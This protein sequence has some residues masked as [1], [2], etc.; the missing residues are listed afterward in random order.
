MAVTKSNLEYKLSLETKEAQRNT[1]KFKG[2][3]KDLNDTIEIQNDS[4]LAIQDNLKEV[5][6][7]YNKVSASLS[8]VNTET[9][10]YVNASNE[11]L[12]TFQKINN[13]L[14]SMTGYIDKVIGGISNL[15]NI[16]EL[17]TSP[18]K[19]TKLSKILYILSKVADFKGYNKIGNAL[20]SAAKELSIYSDTLVEYGF[21]QQNLNDRINQYSAN[22]K[23]MENVINGVTIATI[24]L[25]LAFL[26][27]TAYQAGTFEVVKQTTQA[28]RLLATSIPSYINSIK[29]AFIKDF[30]S[31]NMFLSKF[32]DRVK[33]N[34]SFKVPKLSIK[35]LVIY[36]NNFGSLQEIF[37]TSRR[38]IEAINISLLKL[39]SN[40]S[41]TILNNNW[42]E[43]ISS[44]TIFREKF[45][46]IERLFRQLYSNKGLVI[47][48][49]GWKALINVFSYFRESIF[50]VEIPLKQLTS[51]E[52]VTAF[53]SVLNNSNKSLTVLSEN[54]NRIKQPS[55]FDNM[56]KFFV[57]LKNGLLG[58]ISVLQKSISSISFYSIEID[59]LIH[60]LQGAFIVFKALIPS[61][62]KFSVTLLKISAIFGVLALQ[63]DLFKF[64]LA[65]FLGFNNVISL[66]LLLFTS[67]KG[68]VNE[69]FISINGIFNLSK[70]IL[71]SFQ[72]DIAAIGAL[73]KFI[74]KLSK[75]VI[76]LSQN[77]V[78]LVAVSNLLKIVIISFLST[79]NVFSFLL[80]STVN[81]RMALEETVFLLK[82]FIIEIANAVNFI[83]RTLYLVLMQTFDLFNNIFSN[84]FNNASKFNTSLKQL[85][86][87][88]KG[89]VVYRENSLKLNDI[90]LVLRK[91]AV[92]LKQSLKQLTFDSKA[93]VLF[94]ENMLA[95]NDSLILS[96][97]RIFAINIPFRQL[98]EDKSLVIYQG[99]TKTLIETFDEF[100]NKIYA[101]SRAL[102][103]LAFDYIGSLNI[104]VMLKEEFKSF[105]DTIP[106]AVNIF[107]KLSSAI[108]T[109]FNN[110]YA[111]F[112]NISKNIIS[113]ISGVFTSF[114][115]VL[116]GSSFLQEIRKIGLSIFS[117]FSNIDFK[118]AFIKFIQ[119]VPIVF[120]QVISFF[121]AIGQVGMAAFKVLQDGA[122]LSSIIF[123]SHLKN[124]LI[125]AFEYSTLLGNGFLALGAI[126][127]NTDSTILKIVGTVSLLAGIIFGGFGNA[128]KFALS[129]LGNF[130][131]SIGNFLETT[132]SSFEEKFRK[133]EI[134]IKNFSF[135]MV[136]FS[137]EFGSAIGTAKEWNNAISD[138][139]DNTLI[140]AVDAR[141]MAT[142]IIQVG[143]SLGLTKDQ[144]LALN[145]L[146]PDYVKAGDD[147][148]DVTV[149]FLQALTGMGQGVIKYGLHVSEAAVEHSKYFKGL[150]LSFDMLTES[151]K[152]EARLATIMEQAA[153]VRGRAAEQLNT[154]AGAQ[155]F[156]NNQLLRAQEILGQQNFLI[157][158]MYLGLAKAASVLVSLPSGFLKLVGTFQDVLAVLS[159]ITGVIFAYI[160]PVGALISLY[161][162]LSAAIVKVGT[163]QTIL[164]FVFAKTAITL[165]VTSV[166][167]TSLNTVFLNL[168]I[169]LKGTIIVALTSIGEILLTLITRVALFSKTILLNPLFWKAIAIA[170]A[171]YLVYEALKDMEKQF[172]LLSNMELSKVFSGFSE[173]LENNKDSIET[174]G[175]LFRVVLSTSI[176]VVSVFVAT[177]ISGVSAISIAVLQVVKVLA[178]VQN[179]INRFLSGTTLLVGLFPKEA[180]KNIHIMQEDLEKLIISLAKYNESITG[181][182]TLFEEAQGMPS[183][184]KQGQKTIDDVRLKLSQLKKDLI[185]VTEQQ[186]ITAQVLGEPIKG[187]VLSKQL[188]EE[189]LLAAKELEEKK[190]LTKELFK[191][192]LEIVKASTDAN[193]KAR[194]G[195]ADL[196]IASLERLSTIKAIREASQLKL[197]KELE[198][199]KEELK[200]LAFAPPSEQ[201]AEA[202]DSINKLIVAK[203]RDI[204]ESTNKE[205]EKLTQDRITKVNEANLELAKLVG[206]QTKIIEMETKKQID[207]WKNLNKQEKDGKILNQ[208]QINLAIQLLEQQK[209]DKIKEIRLASLREMQAIEM[210]LAKNVSQGAYDQGLI[211]TKSY[212]E[213][214]TQIQLV[215]LDKQRADYIAAMDKKLQDGSLD[216]IEYAQVNLNIEANYQAQKVALAKKTQDE[217]QALYKESQL[218]Y[219][220]IM[221]LETEA[222]MQEMDKRKKALAD[223][224][225][226][227]NITPEQFKNASGTLER[228]Q[229]SKTPALNIGDAIKTATSIGGGAEMLGGIASGIS[230]ISGAFSSAMAGPIGIIANIP[231]I[232]KGGIDSLNSLMDSWMELP[233]MLIDALPAVI[234]RIATFGSDF[235]TSLADK[236]PEIVQKLTASVSSFMGKNLGGFFKMI[237]K[238]IVGI[239]KSIPA[240]IE[241]IINGVWE[242]LKSL[243]TGFLSLFD[244][245][246]WFGG[247]KAVAE[248]EKT[249]G[250]IT[251]SITG[252]GDVM[253]GFANEQGISRG[254]EIGASIRSSTKESVGWLSR[255]WQGFKDAASWVG[256]KLM[257]FFNFV[258]ETFTNIMAKVLSDLMAAGTFVVDMIVTTVTAVIDILKAVGT[259]VYDAI[260]NS[261]TL[262]IDL[263]KVTFDAVV[264]LFKWVFMDVIWGLV[265]SPVIDL[266]KWL[267]VDVVYGLVFK[268]ILDTFEAL[269]N[270]VSTIFTDPIAAFKNLWT[271]LKN[272]F[273]GI[274]DGFK[275][276]GENLGKIFSKI[277]DNLGTAV[278]NA[279]DNVMNFFSGVG[280]GLKRYVSEAFD[281]IVN[282][283]SNLGSVIWNAVSGAWGNIKSFFSDLFK[284]DGGGKGTVENFLG[285]DFPWV[286]FAK[287]GVVP[288]NATYNGNDKRNDTVPALLSP[289][290]IVL[291]RSVLEDQAFLRVV[292]AKM[293]GEEVPQYAGGFWSDVG[294]GLSSAAGSV[295][296]TAKGVGGAIVQGAKWVG[297]LLVPDWVQ[298]LFDSVSRFI[299][300][301]SLTDMVRDPGGTLNKALKESMSVFS[302]Y[303]MKMMHMS[304]GGFVPGSGY[305]DT[306]PAMLTPGEFVL[307][308]NA[309]SQ[310]GGSVL[311]MLNRGMLPSSASTNNNIAVTLN[312]KTEQPIDENFVRNKIM[313]QLKDE[314]RRMS[315]DGRRILSP[316][317][318]RS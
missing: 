197:A 315:L 299:S 184:M 193:K 113:V 65:S 234:D 265:L 63:S 274:W 259:F 194:E 310:L 213:T 3:V 119:T 44:L 288:G 127:L 185:S 277:W 291:P 155:Q 163:L 78:R 164:N 129:F 170:G 227:G 260:V 22:L 241:G 38:V 90:Y 180:S 77:I 62:L 13:V 27:A 33:E 67:Y 133:A 10:K 311:G 56:Q 235:L 82:I 316:S 8:V 12:S 276:A 300:N 102:K 263:V 31:I 252:V 79:E 297:D 282:F 55:F 200:N 4:L 205:I 114:G 187:L 105:A 279:F 80:L 29:E 140:T 273:A 244:P 11:Q 313:P 305:G 7:L 103:Q 203:T 280:G 45:F 60:Y 192:D 204:V 37:L 211:S 268:P 210:D 135:T 295:W 218:N 317:G 32:M 57:G 108:K 247:D 229:A 120:G 17:L 179:Y 130:F 188:A 23:M 97:R 255:A 152:A 71:A 39:S 182:I 225:A 196:K 162:I 51:S 207:V 48:K 110:L 233:G 195:L 159:K 131:L 121:K 75:F 98:A 301:I 18:E 144:M 230:G 178:T 72:E 232:L 298:D 199:F 59:L 111:S 14:E 270:F 150:G 36:K 231:N 239:I 126:L 272:I 26:G 104:V 52:R 101:F 50:A 138:I 261:F 284:F 283:F 202:I 165:G 308:R 112:I 92:S 314:L 161:G 64:M 312:I 116:Q 250:A 290:E 76:D 151:Q 198:P 66:G 167:V 249:A 61:V 236:L 243:A 107:S 212:Y 173:V 292:I 258:G 86:Y 125:S 136:G 158:G 148:F 157:Q 118:G 70:R 88:S 275:N 41:L 257:Q 84:L 160:L 189:N 201:V 122:T 68:V 96:A 34:F 216:I 74:F 217:M 309:A 154:V 285:I 87:D 264:A 221:G 35:E 149:G 318:V 53:N 141:K 25:G 219:A 253:F 215:E 183:Q 209:Q 93:M 9:E 69:L 177:F 95:V 106:E 287:G 286:A 169:I 94:K 302:S 100:A 139:S 5:E 83:R 171:I 54:L 24:S 123:N 174:F 223:S 2:D 85:T 40:K 115:Q 49:E 228:E 176:K 43:I 242:G 156:L 73:G 208:E 6:A 47:F 294:E 1:R 214:M 81:Y 58:F 191:L 262:V 240:M 147:A 145:N 172:K 281:S 296:D 245:S 168:A 206:D 267:F 28:F 134:S 251:K 256:E 181:S 220:N 19:I 91:S 142:E 190:T 303:F 293:R 269:W 99:R 289:G 222:Y 175:K 246:S 266:F 306:V 254:E 153:A 89:L 271:D 128:I 42:L 132:M 20:G 143:V 304:E 224:L 237:P 166:A 186:L 16:F 117:I 109:L 307:N 278:S 137:R 226:K 248:A 124:S 46:A 15:I 238:L 21:D 30:N 146:I